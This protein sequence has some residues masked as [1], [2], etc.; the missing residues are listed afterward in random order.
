MKLAGML[1]ILSSIIFLFPFLAASRSM[2][3][4]PMKENGEVVLFD[5]D[6]HDL[7][8]IN[9][10][11]ASWRKGSDIIPAAREIT[12]GGEKYVEFSFSGN[13][14]MACSTIYFSDIPDP[15]EGMTYTG[16]M[17]VIDYDRSDYAK[18]SVN[19]S[20]SDKTSM[21]RVLDEC[22]GLWSQYVLFRA[23]NYAWNIKSDSGESTKAQ[24]ESGR[25]VAMR[26]LRN[27]L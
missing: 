5:A 6:V 15:D 20:F 27:S 14:G 9:D 4:T 17:L 22:S 2:T 16:I 19:S 1:T 24:V 3:I 23:A 12:E 18:I 21:I 8:T 11:T 26:K 10:Y 25:L 13:R 7:D